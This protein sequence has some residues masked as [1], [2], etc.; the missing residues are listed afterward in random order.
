MKK[1]PLEEK[2]INRLRHDFPKLFKHEIE[3]VRVRKGMENGFKWE[4]ICG[5]FASHETISKCLYAP[6]LDY[7]KSGKGKA[8]KY[9]FFIK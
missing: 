4:T 1:Q 6:E 3:I 2:L 7:Q 9:V 5:L 8:S